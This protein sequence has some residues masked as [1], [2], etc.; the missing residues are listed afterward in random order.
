MIGGRSRPNSHHRRRSS[1][2]TRV[3]SAE[4]MGVALPDLPISS[5][6]DNINFGDKDS[7]RRK[8]LLALEGRTE[9]GSSTSTVEIP[10]L[11]GICVPQKHFDYR[12]CTAVI[13]RP[14]LMYYKAKPLSSSYSIS[15]NIASKRD[16]FGK[17]LASASSLK[18]QLH[19]LVEEEEEEEELENSFEHGLKS[20]STPVRKRTDREEGEYSER[21]GDELFPDAHAN[22]SGGSDAPEFSITMPSPVPPRHRPA[23][24]TLRPLSLTPNQVTNLPTPSLTPSPRPGLKTLSLTPSIDTPPPATPNS[25]DLERQSSRRQNSLARSPSPASSTSSRQLSLGTMSSILSSVSKRQSSISYIRSGSSSV[26]PTGFTVASLPTPGATP[27]SERRQSISSASDADSTI[28]TDRRTASEEIFIHQ[29]HASLLARIAE[30]E[31]ALQ[32]R[33]RSRPVSAQSDVSTRSEPR[34][35]VL[36]LVADLKAERDELNR[37]IDG[38]RQRVKDLEHAKTVLERRLEAERREGWLRG[39]KLGILEVEKE[40]LCRQL[41]LKEE[42][43]D[44]L[45]HNRDVVHTQLSQLTQER[46][47]IKAHT[48]TVMRRLNEALEAKTSAEAELSTL[49][50]LLATEQAYRK[51]LIQQLDANGVLKTPTMTSK[52][53]SVYSKSPDRMVFNIQTRANGLGFRSIDS[54][55]TTVELEDGHH[56]LKAPF[57]LKAVEEESGAQ[58]Y[59]SEEDN[60]LAR[61]E[62]EEDSDLSFTSPIHSMSSSSFDDDLPR[63]VSSLRLTASTSSLNPASSSHITQSSSPSPSPSPSPCPTPVASSSPND[64]THAKR[65]SLSKTW[66]FPLGE[67]TSSPRRAPEEVDH[68]FGCLEDIDNSPPIDSLP[69]VDNKHFFS[70]RLRFADT[71]DEDMPPFVLPAEQSTGRRDMLDVVMEED[72]EDIDF[73]SEVDGGVKFRFPVSVSEDSLSRIS[74]SPILG[75]LDDEDVHV[76]FVFP[77]MRVQR[78]EHY[79]KR[80][81]PLG[82]CPPDIRPDVTVTIT[83]S[84]PS[85]GKTATQLNPPTGLASRREASGI[86]AV[87]S[88][89]PS[90]IPPPSPPRFAPSKKNVYIPPPKRKPVPVA[91]A[92]LYPS[93]LTKLETPKTPS[94]RP[95]QYNVN[96]NGSTF[97]PQLKSLSTPTYSLLFVSPADTSSSYSLRSIT[98][99]SSLATGF[100]EVP[101]EPSKSKSTNVLE[102]GLPAQSSLFQSF[103]NFLPLSTLSWAPKVI[104]QVHTGREMKTAFVGREKQLNK[105]KARMLA[106]RGVTGQPVGL[107]AT[108]HHCCKCQG[109][110]ISL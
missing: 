70:Q 29:S 109:D 57:T 54:A 99:S 8:A 58:D 41:K 1:V 31:R 71:A 26:P 107:G 25:I 97:I 5:S 40:T 52:D 92:P 104:E 3:E 28:G 21:D 72:E 91:Q 56:A 66:T 60:E 85:K 61:Y 62:D 9:L 12:K 35:E 39:E 23:N 84:T 34:D 27:T 93:N 108:V 20:M 89:P 95:L 36:Q 81:S 73:K 24:L 47:S 46:N 17:L 32:L 103:T 78:P 10:D 110:S 14:F 86:N 50:E 67:R 43:I 96:A 22:R 80:A 105:L 4:M 13:S 59:S 98:G 6:D 100:T 19:T 68:F 90:R 106:H 87:R 15:S 102:T 42:D 38:W 64:P 77:Q 16:S 55:C 45:S 33:P 76:P 49:R 88:I 83:P 2:S 44:R 101:Q 18:D 48:D 11:G 65:A 51:Q 82:G 63:S 94:K 53:G 79:E 69:S 30:L 37:D 74:P 75:Q 7:I